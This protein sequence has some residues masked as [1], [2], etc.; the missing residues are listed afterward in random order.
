MIFYLLICKLIARTH[1]N[2]PG[3]LS[4]QSL[5]S[6]YMVNIC[7][8]PSLCLDHIIFCRDKVKGNDEKRPRSCKINSVRSENWPLSIKLFASPSFQLLFVLFFH[9]K[10]KPSSHF[11]DIRKYYN[12]TYLPLIMCIECKLTFI[13]VK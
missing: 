10:A 2:C 8:F 1:L 7:K 5:M 4:I 12:K 11:M 13:I 9:R 3:H 6:T